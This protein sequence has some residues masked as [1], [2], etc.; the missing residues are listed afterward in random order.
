[1]TW[2]FVTGIL[3]AESAARK[4]KHDQRGQ[5]QNAARGRKLLNH[6][7]EKFLHDMQAMAAPGKTFRRFGGDIARI[8]AVT[9]TRFVFKLRPELG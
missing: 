4:Q 9:G 7:P 2:H 5:Q 6:R 1:M 3:V 8:E